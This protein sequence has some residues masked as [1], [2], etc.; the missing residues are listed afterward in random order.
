M[1]PVGNVLPLSLV[2][3]SVLFVLNLSTLPVSLTEVLLEMKV[4]IKKHMNRKLAIISVCIQQVTLKQ[5]HKKPNSVRITIS[6]PEE[7]DKLE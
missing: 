2:I 4:S 5:L 3:V 1:S 6:F 7:G